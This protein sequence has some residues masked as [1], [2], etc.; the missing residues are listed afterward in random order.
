MT[1]GAEGK[2]GVR[3]SD[4]AECQG[5]LDTFFKHGHTELDT[6]RMY[7]EETTEEVMSLFLFR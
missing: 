6:A 7:A 4:L 2:N 5:I 3:N 1:I